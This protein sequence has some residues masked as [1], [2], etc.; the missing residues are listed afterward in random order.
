MAKR[1]EKGRDRY[2]YENDLFSEERGPG[3]G[4]GILGRPEEP[5]GHT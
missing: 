5:R 4:E 2:L 1:D 3:P